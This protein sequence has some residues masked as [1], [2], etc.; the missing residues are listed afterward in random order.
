MQRVRHQGSALPAVAGR[1]AGGRAGDDGSAARAWTL[2]TAAAE[3][4]DR[5]DEKAGER[6]VAVRTG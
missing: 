6:P 2:I 5:S 4:S 1:A 3:Q